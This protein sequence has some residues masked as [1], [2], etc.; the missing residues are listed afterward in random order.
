MF[1]KFW[2]YRVDKGMGERLEVSMQKRIKYIKLIFHS[3]CHATMCHTHSH[4]PYTPLGL[5]STSLRVLIESIST[6]S[7]LS[8]FPLPYP[9][10][11]RLAGFGECKWDENREKNWISHEELSLWLIFWRLLK[12]FTGVT[13]I[14]LHFKT[15]PLTRLPKTEEW[16]AAKLTCLG[17]NPTLPSFLW[18][19]EPCMAPC[20]FDLTNTG[21]IQHKSEKQ[22]LK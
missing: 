12:P 22:I 16:N 20:F 5:Y 11:L 14:H 4:Q 15:W 1:A 17:R 6:F 8:P 19:E 13:W 7:H 21:T 2:S 9:I 3:Y 10:L 18:I